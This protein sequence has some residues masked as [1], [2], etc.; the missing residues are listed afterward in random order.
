MDKL[1]SYLNQ[2]VSFVEKRI[3]NSPR[4][5]SVDQGND[6]GHYRGDGAGLRN[7]SMARVIDVGATRAVVS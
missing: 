3:P 7:V 1:K 5:L 4:S 2:A 6:A